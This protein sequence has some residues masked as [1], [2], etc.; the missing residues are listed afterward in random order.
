[1]ATS[2]RAAPVAFIAV[3]IAIASLFVRTPSL[4]RALT[5]DEELWLGRSERFVGAVTDLRF[6]DAIETGHPGVTTMWIA[7]IAQRTLPAGASL[8]DRYARARLGM[9]IAASALIVLLWWLA[10]L[11]LG[12]GAA[13]IAGFLLAFDPFLLAHNRVVHLDG[14]LALFMVSSLLALIAAIRNSDKRLLLLSGALGG[15]AL[16]TKQPA[17]YLLPVVLVV[18]W[19][20]GGG[21][22]A[23]TLRWLAAAML[24]VFVLWPILWVRPWHAASVMIGG[25]ESAITETTSSGFFL[26]KLVDDPGPLFYPVA[27]A[28]RSSA[29]ILPAA[30]ATAV[31]AIRRRREEPARTV[32][33]LLLFALGFLVMITFAAKKGDR[34]ALPSLVAIDLA[35]AVGFLEFLRSRRRL[36]VSTLAGVLLVHAAPGLSLHPYELAHFNLLTG[37]PS[38]A[39]RA[40]V[41]GWGEGL[42]E[43][44]EDLSRLPE[45]SGTTVASTRVIQF[46]DFFVGRTVAIEDSTLVKPDGVEPDF[47][48]FYISNVQTGRFPDLWGR[49]RDQ[50]P[51][52]QLEINGI[53]YVRVYRVAP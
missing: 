11:V 14:L 24:V 39:Q 46:E 27:L 1:V 52:Y 32:T 41:V 43:A 38:V 30:I 45:A 18:F 6:R 50:V 10:G 7:G 36:I 25:G 8:R 48:L 16:L 12:Q 35:V 15:L 4:D 37:G 5:I 21:L 13:A 28:L 20:D 23:R 26:G 34:Y 53:P 29:F 9:A 51:F 22:R 42:D 49:Y 47:V 19:R 40:I 33:H 17:V 3:G 2:T 44:A 31:W